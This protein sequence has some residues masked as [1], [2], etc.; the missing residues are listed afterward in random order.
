MSWQGYVDTQ[1]VGTGQCNRACI[2][3]LE[4]SVWATSKDFALQAGEGKALVNAF[5]DPASV[6]GAGI[7]IGGDKMMTIKADSRSIYAK[8]GSSGAVCVKTN[9]AVLIAT[10]DEKI[11]PGQCTT[12]VERLADYLL[13]NNF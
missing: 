12:I 9:Q 6:L 4:G 5:T 8:K 2:I 3:G 1:L 13:E 11:Q 7:R 10:Y